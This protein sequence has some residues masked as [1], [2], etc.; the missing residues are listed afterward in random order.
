MVWNARLND[1][2]VDKAPLWR[3]L[4][5]LPKGGTHKVCKPYV[6]KQIAEKT[7]PAQFIERLNAASGGEWASVDQMC[8]LLKRGKTFCRDTSAKCFA[9]GLLERQSKQF[10]TAKGLNR[11]VR[12]YRVKI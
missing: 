7:T 11:W 9:M 3:Q 4:N 5:P 2:Q 8:E 12:T 1:W 10:K 6:T